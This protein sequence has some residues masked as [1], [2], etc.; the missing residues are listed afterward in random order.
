VRWFRV[1][2]SAAIFAAGAWVGGLA[3]V[4]VS[5][6]LLDSLG[7]IEVTGDSSADLALG[8]TWPMYPATALFLLA[9]W[10][11]LARPRRFWIACVAAVAIQALVWLVAREGWVPALTALA[12]GGVCAVV[13]AGPRFSRRSG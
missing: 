11:L 1:A 5:G 7:V 2:V 10:L 8:V 3:A 12:A 6:Y 9:A 4:F 13:F